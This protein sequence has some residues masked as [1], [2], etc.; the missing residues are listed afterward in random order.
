[1]ILLRNK[2]FTLLELLVV[3]TI[4]AVFAGFSVESIIEF[5]RNTI[6]NDSAQEFYSAIKAAQNKSMSGELLE[7][8][9]YTDYEPAGLPKFGIETSPNSYNLKIKYQLSSKSE[10]EQNLE[11]NSL[12]STLELSPAHKIYFER[13]SGTTSSLTFTIIR[14]GGGGGRKITIDSSG[15]INLENM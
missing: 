12:D 3:V 14:I 8:T 13:I 9:K 7:S 11:S 5:Q 1:M 4:L 2:G 6:L 15:V 10:D